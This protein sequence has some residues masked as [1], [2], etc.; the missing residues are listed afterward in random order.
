MKLPFRRAYGYRPGMI[1]PVKGQKNALSF[2]KY[3]NW[4]F[5]LGK[6]L[7]PDYFS[8]MEE[9]GLSMIRLVRN[10][11]HKSIIYGKD[12]A[13]LAGEQKKAEAEN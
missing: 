1:R 4:I 7:S 9:L 5:P 13:V 8:T 3:V 10:D 6:K 12:I 2:Y 11:Y